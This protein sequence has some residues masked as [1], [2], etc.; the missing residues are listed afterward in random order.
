MIIEYLIVLF[1]QLRLFRGPIFHSNGPLSNANL[2]PQN[3]LSLN[4]SINK[5]LNF[6]TFARIRMT[7]RPQLLSNVAIKLLD[8]GILG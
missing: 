1:L 3:A 6:D 2:L 4:N 5:I 7:M 8:V